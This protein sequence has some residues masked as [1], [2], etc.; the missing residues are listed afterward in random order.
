MKIHELHQFLSSHLEGNPIVEIKPIPD[1][2]GDKLIISPKQT[3][4]HSLNIIDGWGIYEILCK[5]DGRTKV[6]AV[7]D[8]KDT[9]SIVNLVNTF[10]V[11]CASGQHAERKKDL[12]EGGE[13]AGGGKVGE[14]TED[15]DEFFD[16]L[17]EMSEK[18]EKDAVLHRMY[19]ISQ[20]EAT[21]DNLVDFAQ[22][23]ALIKNKKLGEAILKVVRKITNRQ[24]KNEFRFTYGGK[25]GD[26]RKVSATNSLFNVFRQGYEYDEMKRGGPIHSHKSTG[27]Q[28]FDE[29]KKTHGNK[30]IAWN[31]FHTLMGK[32]DMKDAGK[33]WENYKKDIARTR[34]NSSRIKAVTLKYKRKIESL[35]GSVKRKKMEEGGT[36]DDQY[37]KYLNEIYNEMYGFEDALEHFRYITNRSRGKYLT[38]EELQEYIDNKKLGTML[39][40][41]DETA[42]YTGRTEWESQQSSDDDDE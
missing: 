33:I 36:T 21:H 22:G 6:H 27:A 14:F 9:G 25:G 31:S 15:T 40:E 38:E 39:R 37:E 24:Y 32:I 11:A 16:L 12:E 3:N 17:A 19:L 26:V 29:I 13:M 8:K 42:F 1:F 7:V 18:D 30:L 2:W 35:G 23:A 41:Y 4:S 28:T 20:R 10:I 34:G 5:V